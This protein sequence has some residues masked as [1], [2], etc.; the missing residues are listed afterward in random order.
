MPLLLKNY[1]STLF[2]IITGYSFYSSLTY[3]Q[4]FYAGSFSFPFLSDFSFS[5]PQLFLGII[6]GYILWL[7][8]FYYF[9]R[10]KSKALL[11]IEYAYKKISDFRYVQKKEESVAILAWGVKLFFAPLMIF[12]FLDHLMYILHTLDIVFSQN[13]TPEFL[14]FFNSFGFWL[15][16]NIIFFIDVFFFT[17]GYLLESPRLKNTIKSVE[18]TLLWWIVC[19]MCYPPF[20]SYTTSMIGWYSEDFPQFE[21]IPIHIGLNIGILLL[22]CIYS[23][24]SLTLGWKASNLT[25]RGIVT[26]WPYRYIRHPAYLTKNLAWWIGAL[27]MWIFAVSENNIELLFWVVVAT[28]WWTSIYILR[29]LTEEWHLWQDPDYRKY[30]KEVKWRFIPGVW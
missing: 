21:N 26:H 20:N 7:I 14:P 16:F 11:A 19:L 29:A 9:H 12:W 6:I 24:A 23:W 3:Y 4:D 1:F 18:P 8:P 28:L 27:P 2:F 17:V 5:M 13:N 25:N 30:C 15:A 10:E 22:L